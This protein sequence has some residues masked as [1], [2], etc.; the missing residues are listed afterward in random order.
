MEHKTVYVN[1]DGVRRTMISDDDSPGVI[2]VYT[3]A[4][5]TQLVENNRALAELQPRRSTT[6]LLARVPLTVYE[7]SVLEEWDERDWSKWLNDPDNRA[8]RVWQGRV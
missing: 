5:M 1:S 6:K 4:D 8:F 3:E 7:K 2:R